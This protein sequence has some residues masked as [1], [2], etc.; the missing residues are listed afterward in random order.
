MIG[1]NQRK[2]VRLEF[3]DTQYDT[4][5]SSEDDDEESESEKEITTE[6]AKESPRVSKVKRKK[7]RK[8]ER[9]EKATSVAGSK[10][11]N[12]SEDEIAKKIENTKGREKATVGKIRQIVMD[13]L[14]SQ[15]RASPVICKKELRC[16]P[17]RPASAAS[18]SS[19]HH[20]PRSLSAGGH[21]SHRPQPTPPVGCSSAL[22]RSVSLLLAATSSWR[23]RRRCQPWPANM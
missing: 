16:R 14:K 21:S 6:E 13:S 18:V 2:R 5:G 7:E 19:A 3:A 23:C 10:Y 20:V 12:L 4:S 11:G 8:K 1:S 17:C 15:L 9:K 22:Q